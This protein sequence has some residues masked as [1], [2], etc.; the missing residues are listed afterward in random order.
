M[1]PSSPSTPGILG[2][3]RQLTTCKPLKASKKI[4]FFKFPQL[5]KTETYGKLRTNISFVSNL[6]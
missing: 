5:A 6:S 4:A 2:Q 3:C 1:I